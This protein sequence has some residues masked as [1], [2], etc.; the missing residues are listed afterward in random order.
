MNPVLIPQPQSLKATSGVFA[1][2]ARPAIGIPAAAWLPAAQAVAKV[3]R[4][5]TIQAAAPACSYDLRF[6]FDPKLPEEGY[7]LRVAAEGI[8]LRASTARGAFWGAQ[9]LLQLLAQSG[10]KLQGVDISDAPD[11]ADRGYYYD[12]ARGRVPEL[13]RLLELVDLLAA[14]KMNHLELYIEHTF[15][16]RGH[17]DIGKGASP[18]SAQDILTLDA[19][20]A[21]QY[22]ELVP[23]L[24]TFGHLASVL[25]H[26][27]YH[28]LAEDY[29]IGNYRNK[30][31]IPVWASSWLKAW[32]L[33]PANPQVYSFLDSLFAEFLPLFQ[34]KRFNVCCDETWDLGCGQSYDLAKKIGKGELYV[35]HLLKL[36]ELC[37]KY[38][39]QMMFW[40]DI[41]RHHPELL[42][43]LPKDVIVLDWGYGYNHKFETL[44][45]FKKSGLSF[46]ACPSTSTY[47]AFFPRIPQARANTAGFAAAAKK[48]GARGIL[49][50]EWG[51][52]GHYNFLECSWPETVFGAEQSWNTRA[53]QT[54]YSE[55]FVSSFLKLPPA[56]SKKA[57]ATLD[58]LGE[59]SFLGVSGYYQS[60]LRHVFFAMPD[61]KLFHGEE[62]EI[63]E[64]VQGKISVRKGVLDAQLGRANVKELDGI[65]SQLKGWRKQ[66]GADPRGVL[67]YWIFAAECLR[68]AAEK[69][70][71]LTGK[72]NTPAARRKLAGAQEKLLVTFRK[73]WMARNRSSEI[74]ITVKNY[75]AAIKG[76]GK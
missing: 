47:V 6:E 28:H 72:T 48:F 5:A 2:P 60:L 52:G 49:N 1:I 14:H 44:E 75:K 73:L 62:F 54:D 45:D 36:Y 74:A 37:G 57:A 3:L 71:V 76:L 21:A 53:D 29:G 31:D 19:H 18:L 43:K 27:Q 30:D 11:L 50:T 15:A 64:C 61:C 20:A 66:R 22:V 56:I 55:R 58:R 16:F 17:P 12:L 63:T 42:K 68:F 24:A 13:S 10:S 7:R 35:Q 34:S 8:Y 67:P 39:K 25:K 26:P 51:D 46:M 23:S 70:A 33:S 41:I 59:I 40:G 38:G 9:T 65:L 32:T 4:G 69:L